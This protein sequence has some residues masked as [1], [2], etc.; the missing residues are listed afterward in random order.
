MVVASKQAKLSDQIRQA[1]DSSG[2]SR[3]AIAKAI[4]LDQSVLS[5]FMAGTSGLSVQTLDRLGALLK[6]K[7]IIENH[8]T[9]TEGR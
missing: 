7:I 9:K 4:D 6:L 1:I 2:M 5:R 8:A 3:Y